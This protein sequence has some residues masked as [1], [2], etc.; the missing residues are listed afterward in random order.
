MRPS[1]A[2]KVRRGVGIPADL[3]IFARSKPDNPFQNFFLYILSNF[4]VHISFESPVRYQN[5][6]VLLKVQ[7]C[8]RGPKIVM[9]QGLKILIK[10]IC[11]LHFERIEI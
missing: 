11:A 5:V 1:A 3:C 2:G 6:F 4:Q 10:A 7:G 8:S 9:L